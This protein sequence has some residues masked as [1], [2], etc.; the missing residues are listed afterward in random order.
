M[1]DCTSINGVQRRK[2]RSCAPP[3]RGLTRSVGLGLASALLILGFF[4]GQVEPGGPA[5]TL[6]AAYGQDFAAAGQHFASAQDAFAQ[7]QFEL[8]AKEFQA[9]YDITRDPAMLLNI[10][11]S[12]QRAGNGKKALEGYQAYLVAQPQAP[13]RAEVEGRIK[14]IEAALAGPSPGTPAPGATPGSPTGPATPAGSQPGAG[15]TTAPAAGQPAT[16]V[17]ATGAVPVLTP[18][19]PPAPK[20]DGDKTAPEGKATPDKAAAAQPQITPPERPASRLRTAAWVTVAL[21]IALSTS[22]AIVGL[23]AQDRADELRRRTTLLVGTQPPIYDA[24]Q[25]EAYTTLTSEGNAYNQAAIALLSTAG[26]V[27]VTAGILF[28]A[29]YVRRPRVEPKKGGW[30]VGPSLA[31]GLT[32][33]A[34]GGGL[35]ARGSF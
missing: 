25:A 17:P 15:P 28:I 32:G 30:A 6:R 8:A 1:M 14:A 7:G 12:W 31:P 18:K 33:L 3:R 5:L 21:A 26:A 10:G 13:D 23:G 34:T 4:A 27:A 22:G 19:S 20:P 11:E 29:D 9:A 16:D 2:L 35:V 24:G